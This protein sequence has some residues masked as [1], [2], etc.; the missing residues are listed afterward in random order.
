MLGRNNLLEQT[1]FD[2]VEQTSRYSTLSFYFSMLCTTAMGFGFSAGFGALARG[3][4]WRRRSLAGFARL[5]RVTRD[6]PSQ[7][8]LPS[9]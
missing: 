2:N 7:T 8:K 9:H 3:L 4:G 5:E 6:T 1:T